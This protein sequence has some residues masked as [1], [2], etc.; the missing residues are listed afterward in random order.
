MDDI[1]A[2]QR[3][4]AG[5]LV[6]ALF[7]LPGL[8]ER[9]AGG[10]IVVATGVLTRPDL[11]FNYDVVLTTIQHLGSKASV[12]GLMGWNMMNLSVF[13]RWLVL[14]GSHVWLVPCLQY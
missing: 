8:S 10:R 11:E 4:K 6:K 9:G 14:A 3:L 2:V 7:D 13:S 5:D 12:D 1:P